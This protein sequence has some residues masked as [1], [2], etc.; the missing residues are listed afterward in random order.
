MTPGVCVVDTNV[1]ISGLIGVDP[2]SPPAR[3]LDAM[4][5]GDFIYLMSDALLSEYSSVLRRPGL[6]RLH[7]LNDAELD[8]L[9]AELVANAMWRAPV[10]A[11]DTPDT[12]DQHLWAL[13]ASHP[14]G[15]LV[16]GNRLL[17]ENPPVSVSVISPRSFADN[18]L[19]LIIALGFTPVGAT[20]SGSCPFY[21]QWADLGNYIPVYTGP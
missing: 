2:N 12:G 6:V 18:F 1:I 4:L 5:D 19:S 15:Y 7:G 10:A 8:R 17:L 9:L 11:G 20:A 13:L 21:S 16:T 14:Q 3:I